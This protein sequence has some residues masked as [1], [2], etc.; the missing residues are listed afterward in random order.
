MIKDLGRERL[1]GSCVVVVDEEKTSKRF[2]LTRVSRMY[3]C[4]VPVKYRYRW[5]IRRNGITGI[6][7][8]AKSEK[9]VK[10]REEEA[11]RDGRTRRSWRAEKSWG[12]L[13]GY[14]H[15]LYLLRWFLLRKKE[16]KPEVNDCDCEKGML[17]SGGWTAFVFFGTSMFGPPL[18]WKLASGC[19]RAVMMPHDNGDRK[20]YRVDKLLWQCT[21]SW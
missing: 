4:E 3:Y 14:S 20:G 2:L 18:A 10:R 17:V 21:E 15:F 19:L 13:E 6:S 16:N 11:E 8:N 12:T 5:C 9:A 7:R 1:W